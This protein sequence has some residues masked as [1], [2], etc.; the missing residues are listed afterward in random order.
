M[1]KPISGVAA[2]TEDGAPTGDAS[3]PPLQAGHAADVG[4]VAD[5]SDLTQ[6]QLGAN[7]DLARQL[8]SMSSRYETL[9]RE[10][11]EERARLFRMR[12]Q[13]SRARREL[14]DVKEQLAT[15]IS[16]G[17]SLSRQ[18]TLE[19]DEATRR[20]RTLRRQR[21]EIERLRAVEQADLFSKPRVRAWLTGG[22]TSWLWQLNPRQ[23]TVACVGNGPFTRDNFHRQVNAAGW[24]IAR[25]GSPEVSFLVTGRDGWF[26]E[27]ILEHLDAQAGGDIY[28]LSQEM[29]LVMLATGDNP[30]LSADT[31]TLMEWARGHS[32]LQFLIKAGFKWPEVAE[33]VRRV[34]SQFEG[35][36][37][38]P[39]HMMGYSVGWSGRPP[40]ERRRIL[41]K[42]FRGRL[43]DVGNS[44]SDKAYLAMWGAPGSASRLR[45]MA[46]HLW[47]QRNMREE[48]DGYEEA[49]RGWSSDLAW[50]KRN[51]YKPSMSFKWPSTR[52]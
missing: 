40:D 41:K 30:L 27:E 7:S 1:E 25:A 28:V 17:R 32:A 3:E 11:G 4:P 20:E 49:V 52:I 9:G 35:K 34:L 33:T 2:H 29:F 12:E 10:L 16:R 46:R 21:S 50:L 18:L 38:S 51:F 8:G 37:E 42:A 43:P 5:R 6:P 23:M 19:R 13:V 44:A 22:H 36:G 47:Q 15:S 14:A 31:R 48:R 45:R 39:I 24:D 26:E